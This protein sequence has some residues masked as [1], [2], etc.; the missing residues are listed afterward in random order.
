MRYAYVTPCKLNKPT[1]QLQKLTAFGVLWQR[2]YF[3]VSKFWWE[4]FDTC[5][6]SIT[7]H[8]SCLSSSFPEPHFPD[9]NQQL[10]KANIIKWH[11]WKYIQLHY[12]RNANYYILCK[13]NSK[14]WSIFKSMK[15]PVLI[16]MWW[17]QYI[18]ILPV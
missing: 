11:T 2:L 1:F 9:L 5:L 18:H 14:Y 15:Y 4:R 8:I 12:Q 6:I 16:K 7:E 10:E 13:K 3:N 17:N